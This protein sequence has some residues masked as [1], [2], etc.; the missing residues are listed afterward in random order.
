MKVGLSRLPFQWKTFEVAS[1][2][3]GNSHWHSSLWN[4]WQEKVNTALLPLLS[5]LC[6]LS[7]NLCLY[8]HTSKCTFSSVGRET[9]ITRKLYMRFL[10]SATLV[11]ILQKYWCIFLHCR[12]KFDVWSND[13]TLANRYLLFSL[14]RCVEKYSNIRVDFICQRE[15]HRYKWRHSHATASPC[16]NIDIIILMFWISVTNDNF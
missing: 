5:N 7:C 13:V 15:K 10:L 2:S 4:C 8:S 1:H 6:N 3:G 16:K 11:F 12:F 9:Q 14:C